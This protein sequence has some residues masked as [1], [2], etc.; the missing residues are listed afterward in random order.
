MQRTSAAASIHVHPTIAVRARACVC[1]RMPARVCASLRMPC[2]FNRTSPAASLRACLM[3]RAPACPPAQSAAPRWPPRRP[4]MHR[5]A[6]LPSTPCP[7]AIIHSFYMQCTS[8]AAP[9]HV[10]PDQRRAHTCVCL[11][12]HACA[13]LCLFVHAMAIPSHVTSRRSACVPRAPACPPA[14]GAAPRWPPRRPAMHRDAV[15]PST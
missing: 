4:A 2:P 1:V 14:Q 9:V 5:D 10:H 13:C 15:L 6:V 7:S 8:V 12:A 11:S 3:P